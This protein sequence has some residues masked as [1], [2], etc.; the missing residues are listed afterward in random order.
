MLERFASSICKKKSRVALLQL[1]QDKITV[2]YA[3]T[4]KSCLVQLENYDESF[5]LTKF[6]F[7]LRLAILT[8]GFV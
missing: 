6:V 4:F 7:G 3:N 2:Q 8:E 1:M 5:Y